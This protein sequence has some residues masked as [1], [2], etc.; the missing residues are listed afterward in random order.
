MEEDFDSVCRA[1]PEM[2]ANGWEIGDG[3]ACMERCDYG[4]WV[5]YDDYNKLLAAYKELKERHQKLLDLAGSSY[6]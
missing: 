1:D 3:W 6:L 5:S 4:D 2:R